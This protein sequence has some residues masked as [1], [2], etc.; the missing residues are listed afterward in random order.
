MKRQGDSLTDE[1]ILE[2]AYH[3]IRAYQPGEKEPDANWLENF[4]EKYN[5][6]Q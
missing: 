1:M 3:F 4:K 2:K 5:L 6:K